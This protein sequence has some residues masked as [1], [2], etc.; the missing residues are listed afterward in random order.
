LAVFLQVAGEGFLKPQI[1]QKGHAEFPGK[2]PDLLEGLRHPLAGLGELLGV[3]FR[4]L[5]G[6]EG[7]GEEAS[8]PVVKLPAHPAPFLLLGGQEPPRQL[9]PRALQGQE[10]EGR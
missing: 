9:Q 8:Y 1:V 7:S 5:Q 2:P 3:L 4:H 10:E 6:E